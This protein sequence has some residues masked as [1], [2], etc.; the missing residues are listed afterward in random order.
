[1]S[2]RA[3]APQGAS[4]S[5]TWAKI[6]SPVKPPAPAGS[7]QAT[8]TSTAAKAADKASAAIGKQANFSQPDPRQR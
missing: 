4:K 8:G 2:A 6:R 3:T 7:D 5:P 1:M